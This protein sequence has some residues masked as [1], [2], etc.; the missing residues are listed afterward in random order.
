[1]PISLFILPQQFHSQLHCFPQ[2][3][4]YIVLIMLLF[5]LNDNLF[6]PAWC[7]KESFNSN[8]KKWGK[9]CFKR[10]LLAS[11]KMKTNKRCVYFCF[12]WKQKLI[13][14]IVGVI[15]F[16]FVRHTSCYPQS[17]RVEA[18]ASMCVCLRICGN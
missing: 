13:L 5:T 1:M 14:T 17:K 8:E 9:K 16:A 7:F 10:I 18:S 6:A 15:I 3:Y 11:L 4:F 2:I 12:R